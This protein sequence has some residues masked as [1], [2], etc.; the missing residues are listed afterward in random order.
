[1]Y[2][3]QQYNYFDANTGN[4]LNP[5]RGAINAR[6]NSAASQYDSIQVDVTRQFAKGLFFRGAY[7]YGRSFDD[8]SEVFALTF[9]TPTSY[10]AN[11]APGG[12]SQDWG[13]SAFDYR[14]YFTLS[15]VWSPAG[16]H[17][18]NRAADLLLRG[19]TRNFMMSGVTQLQSGPPGTFNL[20]GIDTNGNGSA[21]N[22]R[23]L[24]GNRRMPFTTAGID[25]AY[26]EYPL[27]PSEPP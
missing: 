9:A 17:S 8:G 2:A 27:H 7:T 14:Q 5:D 18:A 25:G 16:F 21:F 6:A 4:R 23:P 15:Y 1:L 20:G 10:P 24:L 12:R 3:N 11:L 26:R 13:P 19:A 22:D